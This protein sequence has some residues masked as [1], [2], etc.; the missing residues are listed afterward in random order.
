MAINTRPDGKFDVRVTCV[1]NGTLIERRKRGIKSKGEAR[2]IE[3]SLNSELLSLKE[4]GWN[5]SFTWQDAL[6]DYFNWKQKNSPSAHHRR[7]E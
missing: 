5:K 6:D 2:N 7:A 1:V 4:K 3:S